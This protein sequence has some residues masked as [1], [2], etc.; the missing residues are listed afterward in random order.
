MKAQFA[1]LD[2]KK[3]VEKVKK[4]LDDIIAGKKVSVARLKAAKLFLLYLLEE[5]NSKRP[6]PPTIC[7]GNALDVLKGDEKS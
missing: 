5:I 1:V 3:R 7:G 4:T 6:F 2:D